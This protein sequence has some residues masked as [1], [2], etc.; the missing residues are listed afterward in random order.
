MNKA[1][2]KISLLAILACVIWGSAFPGAKIG[3]EYTGPIF[4][5]GLRFTLAGLLLVPVMLVL[6]VDMKAPFRYWRFTLVFAFLQ[7][8]MQYGLF[9]MGLDK[10]PASTSAIIIGAG[11]LFVALMA[12]FTLRDDRLT[13]R[14]IGAIALG[15]SGVIFISLTKGGLADGTAPGR[16]Y[17]GI[18]LLIGSNLMGSYTNIM[19]VKKK[20]YG[21][22]PIAL[23][24]F[25]NFTGGLL[26]LV[27]GLI[28]EKP[29]TG[30]F[31][32]E[33]YGALLW[34]ALIPAT[35]FSIWYTLL[36]RPDVK[37]SELNIW[38]FVVPVS[39]CILSWMLLPSDHPTW[40]SLTGIGII[41]AA[42]FLS[43]KPGAKPAKK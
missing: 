36:N 31:P 42:L 13:W 29:Q 27:V 9:F 39:A 5:S 34:L 14:K 3:F 18:A 15:I 4:L 8:F 30:P 7:T 33:F 26:L 10:V 41:T 12:H 20:E 17:T 24:S 2:L 23:T 25:A 6:G 22:S 21:I 38:K 16:F 37:V 11:P 28:A 1:T 35:A 32:A 40:Q 19:V 43:R